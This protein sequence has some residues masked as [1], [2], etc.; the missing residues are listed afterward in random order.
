MLGR[1]FP[2]Y[3]GRPEK[4]SREGDPGE[5]GGVATGTWGGHPRQGKQ[6]VRVSWGRSILACLRTGKE[7]SVLE[8][9]E[10][11]REEQR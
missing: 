4:L 5:K 8:Q 9:R 6:L 3:L 10:Y 7:T 1:M 2:F 11:G